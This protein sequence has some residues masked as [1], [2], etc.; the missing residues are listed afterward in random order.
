MVSTL[1]IHTTMLEAE[2]SWDGRKSIYTL[3]DPSSGLPSSEHP[4]T[5][6]PEEPMDAPAN[7]SDSRFVR[8]H[9]NV[10]GLWDSAPRSA[11]PAWTYERGATYPRLFQLA[12]S[13][14]FNE[15]ELSGRQIFKPASDSRLATIVATKVPAKAFSD[16]QSSTFIPNYVEPARQVGLRAVVL[17]NKLWRRAHMTT[18]PT[19]RERGVFRTPSPGIYRQHLPL[20]APMTIERHQ[21]TG[22]WPQE[23]ESLPVD[24][25]WT[26]QPSRMSPLVPTFASCWPR[27]IVQSEAEVYPRHLTTEGGPF[28]PWLT[29]L[30]SICLLSWKAAACRK[31]ERSSTFHPKLMNLRVTKYSF[32]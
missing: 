16:P 12:S 28:V 11:H 2:Q 21:L 4:P 19:F 15:K 7:F 6:L 31:T 23:S 10:K 3:H 14:G 1:S 18:W 30:L 27:L 17:S 24:A 9:T 29:G 32:I 8:L 26:Q 13:Y 5:S 25:V 22:R 20:I